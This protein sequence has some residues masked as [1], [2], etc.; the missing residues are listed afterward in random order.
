MSL[1]TFQSAGFA[2]YNNDTTFS[3]IS[4]DIAA[5]LP[6]RF[7]PHIKKEDFVNNFWTPLPNFENMEKELGDIE[8]DL[9]NFNI[10]KQAIEDYEKLISLKSKLGDT[11]DSMKKIINERNTGRD[12]IETACDILQKQTDFFYTNPALLTTD[13]NDKELNNKFKNNISSFRNELMNY[14]NY[15][16]NKV[17]TDNTKVNYAIQKY[18]L[19]YNNILVILNNIHKEIYQEYHKDK[20]PKS[21]IFCTVCLTN[22]STHVS[23]PCGHIFCGDCITKMNNNCASCR[24]Q[25]EKIIKLYNLDE[26]N[27]NTGELQVVNT[28]NVDLP[29]VNNMTQ[30]EN[31]P[32]A[33]NALD[34]HLNREIGIYAIFLFCVKRLK[35]LFRL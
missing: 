25:I 23:V 29:E 32:V 33:D 14:K 15:V 22:G 26:I 5:N 1:L 9:K 16:I 31:N 3:I 10:M 28:N 11:L 35:S 6:N 13:P 7:L 12:K 19:V 20:M 18:E 30:T 17:D 24:T 27:T 34:N 4:P 2:E 8:N 21:N